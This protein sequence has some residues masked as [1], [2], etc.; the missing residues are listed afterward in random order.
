[1]LIQNSSGSADYACIIG[2][3]N[4]SRWTNNDHSNNY[5]I[6][7]SEAQ[8][9]SDV[10]NHEKMQVQNMQANGIYLKGQKYR[11]VRY[12]DEDGIIL[13]KLKDYGAVSIQKSTTAIVMAHT[14]EGAAQGTTN[15]GLKKVVEYLKSNNM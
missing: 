5:N 3:G 15:E 13:G 10:M 6:E 9:F 8:T 12:D 14:K 1:M 2:L 11:F 7:Q 4:A